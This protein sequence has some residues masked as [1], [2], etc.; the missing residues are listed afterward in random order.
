MWT[1]LLAEGFSWRSTLSSL[2]TQE[3]VIRLCVFILALA[4]VIMLKK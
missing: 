3:G 4:L 2:A 1:C